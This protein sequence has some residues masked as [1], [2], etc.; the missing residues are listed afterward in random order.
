MISL[1]I[2]PMIIYSPSSKHIKKEMVYLRRAILIVSLILIISGTVFF[3]N[4]DGW[5]L[6]TQLLQ[7]RPPERSTEELYQDI[8]VTFLSPYI[9]KAVEDYYGK[10]YSVAPYL[11]EVLSVERPNGYRTF[12]FRIKL[13][14]R[15]Y[16]GPH[17][18]V[19]EDN[20]TILVEYDPK[21]KVEK[22]EHIKSY[23]LPPHYQ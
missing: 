6:R 9:D 1:D 17:I 5:Q 2:F 23:E 19:G 12:A 22:F 16:I 7:D 21:V 4:V 8:F 18:S 3:F 11:T 14:I 10:P 15:P 13:K 20:I